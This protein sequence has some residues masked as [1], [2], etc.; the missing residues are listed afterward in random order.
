MNGDGGMSD[1]GERDEVATLTP[2]KSGYSDL[3]ADS[4]V[5]AI[6]FAP[7]R[8]RRT[9]HKHS[10]SEFFHSLGFRFLTSFVMVLGGPTVYFI[11]TFGKIAHFDQSFE[12]KFSI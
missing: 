9:V 10:L 5:G 1:D 2:G 12:Q 6:S 7:Q 3:G 4:A 8:V 11:R